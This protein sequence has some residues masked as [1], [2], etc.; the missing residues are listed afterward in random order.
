MPETEKILSRIKQIFEE[1]GPIITKNAGQVSSTKKDDGSP[2]TAIDVEVETKI[3]DTLKAEFPEVR[4]YGEESDYSDSEV[5]EGTCWLFD[6]IDGTGGFLKNDGNFTSMAVCLK[7]GQPIA[8]AIHNPTSKNTY[9]AVKGK[10]AYKN[11]QKLDLEITT[12]ERQIYC[13]KNFQPT[14][15]EILKPYD[16]QCI[17][18]PIGAGNQFAIISEGSTIG[19]LFLSSRGYIH[20]YATGALLFMEAGGE[21]IPLTDKEYSASVKNFI[22]CHPHFSDIFNA[23]KQKI[24]DYQLE[25]LK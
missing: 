2:V 9:W 7:D 5:M 24:I 11:N 3:L 1:V 15:D 14:I 25:L 17:D 23:C 10:G 19:R 20:D 4:F 16:I 8:C 22:A 6:P 18:T 13:K 12:P 21:I